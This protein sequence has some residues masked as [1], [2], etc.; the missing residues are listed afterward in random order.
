MTN[1]LDHP[2]WQDDGILADRVRSELG[3][4]LKHLD[5]PRIHVSSLRG[6]VILRGDVRDPLT[7]VAIEV[8]AGRVAGVATVHSYLQVGLRSG[9]SVPSSGR[10]RQRSP[11]LRTLSHIVEH[12]GYP[13]ESEQRF[14]LHGLLGAFMSRLSAGIRHRVLAHLPE[15]VRQLA[16]PRALSAAAA[17]AGESRDDFVQF[18][19]VVAS[20]DRHVAETLLAALLAEVRSHVPADADVVEAALPAALR[21]L[22][23]PEK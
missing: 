20:V 23:A 13:C 6:D 7:R 17:T 18:A 8:A 4:L 22:W 19:G 10:Q 11:M 5:Q 14:I 15:D 1:V 12:A 16:T 3:P 9:E 21:P 2:L